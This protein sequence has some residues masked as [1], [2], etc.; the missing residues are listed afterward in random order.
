[1][2]YSFSAFND[3]KCPLRGYTKRVQKYKEVPGDL[4]LV[5]I[6]CS[7]I[8]EQYRK[9]CVES[10]QQSDTSYL[11][12]LVANH[13]IGEQSER[14]WLD[15]VSVIENMRDTEIALLDPGMEGVYVEQMFGIAKNFR[16]WLEDPDRDIWGPY[17]QVW[18]RM[19]PDFMYRIGNTAIV[20]DDKSG[21]SRDPDPFQLQLYAW[22]ASIVYK[23]TIE[24]I[25]VM[26]NYL[27]YGYRERY[28][29][30]PAHIESQMP[31]MISGTIKYIEGLM[32][33]KS[34][35]ADPDAGVC[36]LCGFIN[37][38]LD[39]QGN[40][41]P[42]TPCPAIQKELIEMDNLVQAYAVPEI[43]DKETVIKATRLLVVAGT[44]LA[45]IKGRIGQYVETH[46]HEEIEAAGKKPEIRARQS[47]KTSN[48]EAVTK[49]LL[50]EGVNRDDAWEALSMNKT[51]QKVL[52][53]KYPGITEKLI[54]SG[55]AWWQETLVFDLYKA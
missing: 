7:Q 30:T 18:M 45:A 40:P 14:L 22:C 32:R 53:R 52:E 33:S 21:W 15:T 19:V 37:G 23:N 11:D 39:K 31:T 26:F 35:P 34:F 9:H 38:W 43:T 13:P 10:N 28:D 51:G 24:H 1:V 4:Q 54:E 12:E 48:I 42:F 6:A 47:W 27:R 8:L 55:L 2:A 17:E 29:F 20:Q 46:P 41:Q 44:L 49:F 3:W 16:Y 25:C 50:A 5:G 36:Q